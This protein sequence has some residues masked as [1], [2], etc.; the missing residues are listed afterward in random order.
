MFDSVWSWFQPLQDIKLGAVGDPYHKCGPAVSESCGRVDM[1]HQ[2]VISVPKSDLFKGEHIKTLNPVVFPGHTLTGEGPA[3]IETGDKQKIFSFTARVDPDG[4]IVDG[5][6]V[7]WTSPPDDARVLVSP[8]LTGKMHE[9][10]G[11]IVTKADGRIPGGIPQ[12]QNIVFSH[13]EIVRRIEIQ[14]RDAPNS[15]KTQFGVDQV[16]LVTNQRDVVSSSFL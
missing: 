15:V 13:P 16:A 3:F 12:S 11:W 9:A 5:L 7:D 2:G 1:M 6:R 8:S 4:A 10:T 14:M